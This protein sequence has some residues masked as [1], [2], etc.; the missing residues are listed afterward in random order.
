MEG[1][2]GPEEFFR[3]L[4]IAMEGTRLP[5]D[6]VEIENVPDDVAARIRR[7]GRIVYER[8]GS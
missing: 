7:K 2:K 6:V 1:L 4:G 3:A 5:V 8:K